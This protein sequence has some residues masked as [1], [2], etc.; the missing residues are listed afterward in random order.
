MHAILYRQFDSEVEIDKSKSRCVDGQRVETQE[1]EHLNTQHG[2]S[3]DNVRKRLCHLAVKCG[4]NIRLPICRCMVSS[5]L[6]D[7][8]SIALL[9][10]LQVHVL[11]SDRK[12][13]EHNAS[14]SDVF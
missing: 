7:S 14:G 1:Q 8:C 11:R 13:H 12:D 3:M 4:T 6:L 9:W 10:R 5:R 2:T